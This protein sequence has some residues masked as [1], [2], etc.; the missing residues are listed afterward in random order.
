MIRKIR[1]LFRDEKVENPRYRL[2]LLGFF[3]I[4]TLV[5]FIVPEWLV[6]NEPCWNHTSDIGKLVVHDTN[7]LVPDQSNAFDQRTIPGC[8]YDLDDVGDASV[9]LSNLIAISIFVIKYVMICGFM[10]M[11]FL[12]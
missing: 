2:G 1:N 11:L 9:F 10:L 4:G 8:N 12:M 5:L 6:N 3:A 7:I